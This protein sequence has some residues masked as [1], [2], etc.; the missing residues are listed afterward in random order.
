M[1]FR[2]IQ[3]MSTPS[4][5]KKTVSNVFHRVLCMVH[6]TVFCTRQTFSRWSFI[7]LSRQA[8]FYWIAVQLRLDYFHPLL[9]V[10]TTLSEPLSSAQFCEVM[11]HCVVKL[12]FGTSISR[13]VSYVR[14]DS[15][16]FKFGVGGCGC[17]GSQIEPRWSTRFSPFCLDSFTG[18]LVRDVAQKQHRVWLHLP[19]CFSLWCVAVYH[20]NDFFLCNSLKLQCAFFE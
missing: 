11:V 13:I 12:F 8:S 7:S 20:F 1:S 10:K 14:A 4:C 6:Y 5:P 19:K 15:Y 17:V 2:S 16:I 3:W 9:T 18:A